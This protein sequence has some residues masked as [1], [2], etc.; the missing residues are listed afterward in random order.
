MLEVEEM[1]LVS[2]RQEAQLIVNVEDEGEE[3]EKQNRS[4]K[5]PIEIQASAESESSL[6]LSS[7]VSGPKR[8]LNYSGAV[9]KK[10]QAAIKDALVKL[11]KASTQTVETEMRYSELEEIL[12]NEGH[13]ISHPK[14]L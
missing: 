8:T 10:R 13:T 9:I 14:V 3:S 2:V 5:I 6:S 7:D 11:F 12:K 1:E 4:I